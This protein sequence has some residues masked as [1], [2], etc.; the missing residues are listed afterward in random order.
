MRKTESLQLKSIFFLL[1]MASLTFVGCKKQTTEPVAIDQ[2]QQVSMNEIINWVG[3][4]N[5]KIAD[6]PILLFEL[7]QKTTFK[8]NS[9][10][11]VP[12]FVDSVASGFFYFSKGTDGTLQT[13]YVV[14]N[15]NDSSKLEGNVGFVDFDHKSITVATYQDNKPIAFNTLKNTNSV[16]NDFFT[17]GGSAIRKQI[18]SGGGVPQCGDKPKSIWQILGDFFQDVW[19]SLQ[20]EQSDG[21][22]D[23]SNESYATN[24]LY[25]DFSGFIGNDVSNDGPYPVAWGPYNSSTTG[26]LFDIYSGDG[27][28]NDDD[29]DNQPSPDDPRSYFYTEFSSMY[30]PMGDLV[31][32][33]F[34]VTRSDGLNAYNPISIRLIVAVQG[35]IELALKNGATIKYLHISATTNGLHARNSNHYK[36]LALDISE[37]NHEKI[38]MMSRTGENYKNVILLQEAFETMANRRENFGPHLKLKS[39]QQAFVGGHEDHIHFSINGK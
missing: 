30:R 16:F 32:T 20:G 33:T 7:A 36:G 19:D 29:L 6:Q 21:V 12:A 24:Y 22:A 27:D 17:K 2:T 11:R 4:L 37:I 25:W 28:L 13:L 8:G 14:T 39:G 18:Y 9:Y 5:L 23:Y 10:I 38:V 15:Q 1:L 26:G 35:A 3:A 34:G 31:L